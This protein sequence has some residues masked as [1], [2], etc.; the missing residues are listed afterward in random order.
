MVAW[1]QGSWKTAPRTLIGKA[2]GSPDHNGDPGFIEEVAPEKVSIDA[3]LEALA[4]LI[5]I[6]ARSFA[7]EHPEEKIVGAKLNK[8]IT[9]LSNIIIEAFYERHHHGTCFFQGNGAFARALLG[10]VVRKVHVD[11]VAEKGWRQ[12]ELEGQV[13]DRETKCNTKD[14]ELKTKDG[15]LKAKGEE[16]IKREVQLEAARNLAAGWRLLYQVVYGWK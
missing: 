3:M 6:T 11:T 10:E 4:S 15:E 14:E 1:L 8:H 7:N 16:L 9:V 2:Q 12:I 13:R 5:S